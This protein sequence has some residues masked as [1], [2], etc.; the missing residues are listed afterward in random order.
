MR[1]LLLFLLFTLFLSA[2]EELVFP[3]AFLTLLLGTFLQ[4]LILHCSQKESTHYAL[5]G[6]IH[7]IVLVRLE[8]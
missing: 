7:R 3:L 6:H 2:G 5:V 1:R 4:D 8:D